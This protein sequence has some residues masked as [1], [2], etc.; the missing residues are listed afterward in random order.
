MRDILKFDIED[1][2]IEIFLQDVNEHLEAMESGLLRLEQDGGEPAESQ[3]S[4]QT[5]FRAAHT[6]KAIAAAVGHPRMAELTHTIENTFEALREGWLRPTAA[7][8]DELLAAVDTL[9]VLRDEVVTREPSGID[10]PALIHWLQEM[11][12]E[13]MDVST[14]AAG[15]QL[16]WNGDLSSVIA[17]SEEQLLRAQAYVEQGW[18]LWEIHLAAKPGAFAPLARLL[19]ASMALMELGEIIVQN[20]AQAD[21][22]NKEETVPLWVIL[23]T[24]TYAPTVEAQLR[25]I[26]DIDGFSV[27]PYTLNVS[28]AAVLSEVAEPV[29]LTEPGLPEEL[30]AAPPA[31]PTITGLGREKTVRIDV[32]RLD[33]LMNLVGE[34]VTGRTRLAQVETMLRNQYG[35]GTMTTALSELNSDL[36]R[37]V[38]QLQEEVMQARMVPIAQLFSKFPRLIRDVAR[39]AHKEVDFVIEG[40]ATEL[41]RAVIELIGDPLVHLLRNAVDHGLESTQVRTAMGKAARGTVRLSAAH[42]EGNVVITVQDDGRGID[43]AHVRQA[44]VQRGLLSED[45]AAKLDA[46]EATAL[47]FEPNFSTADHVTEVSGRGV[48]LDVVRTNVKR[49]GG[50]VTVDSTIGQGSTFRLS[51]PLT[52][53]IL[54]TMLVN[55]GAEVYAIPLTGIIESLYLADWKV[56]RVR[57][58]SVIY[59]RG[60]ALP[61]LPLQDFFAHED[62]AGEGKPAV[63]VVAWGKQRVGLR[64]DGLIGKEEIVIK[65]MSPLVGNVPGISGCTILGDGRVALIVDVPGLIGAALQAR[66]QGEVL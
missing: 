24:D 19:Q 44:A 46:H 22:L 17:L 64:V 53:A 31:P 32:E 40:E 15:P 8:I 23:A 33:A 54:Q 34:L 66:R 29:S 56:S 30:T 5:A 2:E 57:G 26:T 14:A 36:G 35:K 51:L 41:D 28:E 1:N 9:R 10:V 11:L 20:P 45:A 37:V 39:T 7:L 21:L 49:L 3:E 4:L 58:K 48:G 55:V 25:D 65:S 6:L 52:L 60:Q 61:L 47:I 43:P 38:D 42:E 27:Q 13:A 12:S 62:G 50:A 18:H 59:W 16:A 63:V